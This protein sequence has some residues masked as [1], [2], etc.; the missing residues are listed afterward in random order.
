M[1]RFCSVDAN[2][3]TLFRG[4]TVFTKTMELVMV[5]YGGSFLENALGGVIRRLC[6][7][8]VAI[9]TDPLRSD[10]QRPLDVKEIDRNAQLL[11]HWCGEF[12]KSIYSAR[13]DCPQ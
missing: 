3:N 9:E 11:A 2:P 6:V 4:N 8:K 5:Q 13:G 10:R 12:W 7:E 1:L